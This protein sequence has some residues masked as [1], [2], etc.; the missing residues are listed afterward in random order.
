MSTVT[1]LA[2][3]D[4]VRAPLRHAACAAAA[5]EM[6]ARYPDLATTPLD[7]ACDLPTTRRP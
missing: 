7:L 3:R 5:R 6:L 2:G 4:R 1:H